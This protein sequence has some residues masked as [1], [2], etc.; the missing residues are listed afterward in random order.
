MSGLTYVQLDP[1]LS[2]VENI[3][4]EP[5]KKFLKNDTIVEMMKRS[6]NLIFDQIDINAN[7]QVIVLDAIY[8]ISAWM[9]F[10]TFGQSISNQLQLQ[11]IGAF[12]ENLRHYKEVALQYAARIG[13]NLEAELQQP[14]SDSLPYINTGGSL[15]DR[16]P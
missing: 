12:R 11:D 2:V 3:L 1:K 8:A 9:C 4:D 15:L 5:A 13:V 14:L 6:Y 10:G 7:N 16:D